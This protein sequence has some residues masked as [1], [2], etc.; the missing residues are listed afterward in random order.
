[1][2]FLCEHVPLSFLALELPFLHSVVADA[3][4]HMN[5]IIG[6]NGITVLQRVS[7]FV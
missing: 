2:A 1:M 6:P 4:V 7:D 5:G 3:T